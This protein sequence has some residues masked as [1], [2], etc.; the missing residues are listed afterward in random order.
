MAWLLLSSVDVGVTADSMC[1][2]HA[3]RATAFS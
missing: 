2:C 1:L 3:V